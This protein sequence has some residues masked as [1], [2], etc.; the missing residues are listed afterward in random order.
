MTEI[1]RNAGQGKSIALPEK[2]R[3]GGILDFGREDAL[4]FIMD[5][6]IFEFQEGKAVEVES[7]TGVLGNGLSFTIEKGP[8]D[9][10]D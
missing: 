3:D 2:F 7:V 5:G 1:G 9:E 8:F 6:R 10:D 4:G